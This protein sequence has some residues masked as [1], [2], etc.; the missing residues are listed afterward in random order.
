MNR[1]VLFFGLVSITALAGAI[2]ACSSTT[3]TETIVDSGTPTPEGGSGK[4][5]GKDSS[6]PVDEDSGTST[7]PDKACTQEATRDACGQCCVANHQ[8]GSKV[9]QDA[10]LACA[11]T[12][13]G[14]DGGAPACATECANTVCKSPPA[15][16]DMGC[17]TCLQGSVGQ[18]GTCN[19]AVVDACTANADCLDQ[20]K[21]IAACP[22]N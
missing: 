19:G 2:A 3:T 17:S 18:T 22:A 4:D 11:C 1:N 9:F 13:T 8:A 21:C 16:P 12:G 7:D 14:A 15:N 10:L 5:G 20:Q 6:T